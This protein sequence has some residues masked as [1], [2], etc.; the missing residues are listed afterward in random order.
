MCCW[1][2]LFVEL[3]RFTVKNDADDCKG[4]ASHPCKRYWVP[5]YQNWDDDRHCSFGIPKHLEKH[6]TK[7]KQKK[8]WN[9]NNSW[10]YDLYVMEISRRQ[11]NHIA[12]EDAFNK[13]DLAKKFCLWFSKGCFDIPMY[14]PKIFHDAYLLNQAYKDW[15][16]EIMM[17]G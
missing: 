7:T 13:I 15:I 11:R 10:Y 6:N 14:I 2:T 8:R 5:K 1:N 17:F 4:V 12:W 9:H 16:L 3:F